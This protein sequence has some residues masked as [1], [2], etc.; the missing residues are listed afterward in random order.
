MGPNIGQ[1]RQFVESD[2]IGFTGVAA[3]RKLSWL[4]AAGHVIVRF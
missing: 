4:A 1:L 3:K 2:I